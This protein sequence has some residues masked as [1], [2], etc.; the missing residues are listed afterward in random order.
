MSLIGA[1]K[2]RLIEMTGRSATSAN[3]NVAVCPVR[4]TIPPA[5][6]STGRQLERQV[7]SILADQTERQGD[8]HRLLDRLSRR[9]WHDLTAFKRIGPARRIEIAVDRDLWRSGLAIPAHELR[10]IAFAGVSKAL[11]KLLYSRRLAV[12]A[13]EIEIHAG[14]E[15]VAA[16]QC[17]HHPHQFG[18]FFVYGG[19][20]KV[21]DFLVALGPNRMRQRARIFDELRRA[22]TAHINDP[23][24]RARS[25]V[26]RKFLITKNR[27]AFFQTKLKPIAAGDAVASPVVEIFM[28]DYGFDVRKIGVGCGVGNLP[29]RICR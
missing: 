29:A 1:E 17:L 19:R 8:D 7:A 27:E 16:D 2:P 3:S 4:T 20:V 14:P 12:V 25:H 28:G 9:R 23:L 24:H 10:Q 13:R 5:I 26:G 11:D 6:A 22:K 21:I 15:F 18:T